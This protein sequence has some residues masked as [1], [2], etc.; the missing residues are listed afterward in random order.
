MLI[1][2]IAA[3]LPAIILL[4]YIRFKDKSQPE[5]SKWIAKGFLFGAISTMVSTLI[6]IPI[7]VLGFYS[8]DEATTLSEAISTAFFGAAI[9]EEAAKLLMLWLL[10]RKNPFF[11][12]RID[13]IVYA[14]CV[15]MGFASVENILYLASSE[16]W[17]TVGIMRALISVPGHFMFAVAMG[18]YYSKGYW[19]HSRRDMAFAFLVPM[20]LHGVFDAILM[21]SDVTTSGVATVLMFCFFWFFIKVRKGASNKINDLLA[22]DS[23]YQNFFWKEDDVFSSDEAD[24]Q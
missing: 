19:G 23:V 18:Y 13:G 14:V 11:D 5:P 12:E 15:G 2:I 21:V 1:L 8:A 10:L 16:D 7:G 17:L 6:V 9:P 4:G 20:A 22:Q 24:E 3:L